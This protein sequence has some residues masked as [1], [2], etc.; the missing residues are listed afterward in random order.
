MQSNFQVGFMI[1]LGLPQDFHKKYRLTRGK[2]MVFLLG[3][4]FIDL[5]I[6]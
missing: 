5:L 6:V 4:I 3:N 2:W 1:R